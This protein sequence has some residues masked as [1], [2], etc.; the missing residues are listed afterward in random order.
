M[1]KKRNMSTFLVGTLRPY[2]DVDGLKIRWCGR[3]LIVVGCIPGAWVVKNY[4]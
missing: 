4:R 3:E 1:R 2:V